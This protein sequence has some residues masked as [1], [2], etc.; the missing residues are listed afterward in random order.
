[1]NLEERGGGR[2]LGGVE[3]GEAEVGTYCKK[4]E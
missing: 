2:G 1:M 3:G 4:D